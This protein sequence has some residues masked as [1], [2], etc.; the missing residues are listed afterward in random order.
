M[1][2]ATAHL[3]LELLARLAAAVP[4]P[5]V[6]HGSSGVPPAALQDAVRAGIRK[7]NVGTALNAAL[8]AQVRLALSADARLTDPRRYLAPAREAVA[9][10]VAA[11]CA[12]IR[13]A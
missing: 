3:D 2:T 1:T 8:T 11:S 9:E 5:L 12:T 10:V 4:V 7:I 6:L 13:A